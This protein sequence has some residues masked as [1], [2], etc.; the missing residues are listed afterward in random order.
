VRLYHLTSIYHLPIILSAGYLKLV[1]SN[2]SLIAH[3]TH[4]GPDVVWLTTSTRPGQGWAAMPTEVGF[5]D[6][7]RIIFD[8]KVPDDKVFRW[9]DWALEHGSI[10]RDMEA[11]AA[12]G[13]E[14]HN[15]PS[16]GRD[17]EADRASLERARAEWFVVER[18]IP[19]LEWQTVTDRLAGTVIWA[20]TDQQVMQAT[21]ALPRLWTVPGTVHN[22]VM[23]Q[24]EGEADYIPTHVV[25]EA[26]FAAV[27]IGG[28][29]PPDITL[30]VRDVK[31]PRN[32][33]RAHTAEEVRDL[34]R[35]DDSLSP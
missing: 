27:Q 6:K 7:T 18:E 1:E 10:L 13:D 21:L 32:L 17:L 4:K 11:L 24:R 12:S 15:R 35:Q 33:G 23:T 2:I 34:L 29:G 3:E 25:T 8:V 26:E 31:L 22:R 20:N 14:R 9:Y 28:G 5:V 30:D 16:I 19:W